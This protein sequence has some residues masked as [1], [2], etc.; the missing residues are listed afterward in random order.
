MKII[1]QDGREHHT[2][3]VEVSGK[4]VSCRPD[5][6][7]RR[8]EILGIY[9]NRE[10]AFQVQADIYCANQNGKTEFIMPQN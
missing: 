1:G 4:I 6:D 2:H 9:N 8:K 10:L 7:R 5:S 3:N